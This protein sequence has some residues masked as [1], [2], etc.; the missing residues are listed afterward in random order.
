MDCSETISVHGQESLDDVRAGIL[1]SVRAVR[2]EGGLVH[3]ITNYVTVESCADAVLAVGASPIMSDEPEDVRD[4]TALCP[5]LV[6]NIGTLNSHTIEGMRVAGAVAAK[7]SHAIVL[8]PVGAGA[9]PLRTQI[10]CELL[11]SLP[12]GILRGNVSE[13]K[14]VSGSASSTRGVDADPG[15]AVTDASVGQAAAFARNVA[16]RTGAV[17]A[18]TGAIDIVADAERAFAVRNGDAL[19]GRITGCGCMLSAISG[20]YA[21]SAGESDML[22]AA[23]AAVVHMGLAGQAAHRRMSADDGTGS[24]RVYLMDALSA[25]TPEQIA[26][27]ARIEEVR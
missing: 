23:L 2:A 9:S 26:S 27:G 4:I 5:A 14:A 12:V 25:L 19:Q 1:K 11:D 15:D 20:A 17:V 3:C 10:A 8:D 21:A 22:E 7:L 16:A 13:I 6:I 24:F 18:M